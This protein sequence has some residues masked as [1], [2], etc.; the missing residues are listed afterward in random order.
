MA[1]GKCLLYPDYLNDVLFFLLAAVIVVV[2]FQRL[3]LS[4]VLGYFIAGITIGPF[5]IGFIDDFEDTRALADFGVLFL[6]FTMGLE[7]PF[8]RLRV[9]A[10]YVFGLGFGQ[11]AITTVAITWIASLCGLTWQSA[12]LVGVILS[13][14]PTAIVLQIL[15]ERN[16]LTARFGRVAFAVLLAQDLAVVIVLVILSVARSG[17]ETSLLSSVVL[18]VVK[19]AFVLGAIVLSGRVILRPIYRHVAITNNPELFMATT[20]LVVLGTSIATAAAGLS[21]ALGAFIAGLLLAESEYRHQVEGDIEPFRGLLLG[22]FFMT[23][24][25]SID[26]GTIIYNVNMIMGLLSGMV[27][28]KIIILFILSRFFGMHTVKALRVS[29]LLST[30][31]EFAFVLLA[32]STSPGLLD[33]NLRDILYA[34]VALSMALTPFLDAFIRRLRGNQFTKADEIDQHETEDFKGH[35]IIGGFGR[36]GQVVAALMQ[37]QHI[38]HVALDLKMSRV[39]AGRSGG[40]QVF[41]GDIRRPE[42]V[43]ALGA[44]RARVCVIT[45]DHPPSSIRAVTA[46]RRAFPNLQI[47]ARV[48]DAEHGLKLKELGVSIIPPEIIE[49]SIQLGTLVL[50]SLNLNQDEVSQVVDVFRKTYDPAAA[51]LE[52]KSS[53]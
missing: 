36:V 2:I 51:I 17:S 26:V 35:I 44:D 32:P 47:C 23:V 29:F 1:E 15:A 34:T 9:L 39:A 40:Y 27:V 25:M 11:V 37:Q 38:P 33:D 12:L 18:A 4:P 10:R 16:E 41:F 43:R 5:G 13:L 7:L 30:G 49:P 21:M 14:S 50:Q 52:E 46:L 48:R 28:V 53:T 8:Q 19:A 31:G 3:R 22:L 45:L 6:L 20:L 42:V 24:G